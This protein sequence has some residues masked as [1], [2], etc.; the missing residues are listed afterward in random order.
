MTVGPTPVAKL[1]IEGTINGI[2]ETNNILVLQI[3]KIEAP[4]TK[5]TH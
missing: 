3:D 4:S 2:D 1:A 5:L